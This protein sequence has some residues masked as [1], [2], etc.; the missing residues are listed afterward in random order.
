MKFFLFSS[1]ILG[2]AF[3]SNAQTSLTTAQ[4]FDSQTIEGDNFDLFS[5]LNDGKHVILD[6]FYADCIPCQTAAPSLQA[7]YERYGCNNGEVFFLSISDRDAPSA[8]TQFEQTYGIEL[9]AI[10]GGNS[11]EGDIISFVYGIASYPSTVL[12]A[13]N[14]DILNQNISP[15]NATNIDNVMSSAGINTNPNACSFTTS[16]N[17]VGTNSTIFSM[18]NRIANESAEINLKTSNTIKARINIYDTLGKVLKQSAFKTYI[19]GNH[20]MTF[21][22]AG[23]ANGNYIIEVIE[24]SKKRE[25]FNL[26]IQH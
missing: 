19:K 17:K 22:T 9:P 26:M 15:V 2:I 1:F 16:I 20:T 14:K 18:K 12:I 7:A 5:V 25:A 23:I 3:S 13:P 24:E 10:A 8:I 11:G 6:F 4:A 21:N